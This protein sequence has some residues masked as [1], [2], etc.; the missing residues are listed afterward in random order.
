MGPPQPASLH[1]NGLQTV[2]LQAA[3]RRSSGTQLPE[4]VI[5]NI[6]KFGGGVPRCSVLK[7]KAYLLLHRD[8]RRN[9]RYMKSDR[10]YADL[11]ERRREDIFGSVSA[12]ANEQGVVCKEKCSDWNS[13]TER[14]ISKSVTSHFDV[15]TSF[16]L[17]TRT[18]YDSIKKLFPPVY[19]STPFDM[20]LRVLKEK[21]H[22]FDTPLI[23]CY[24]SGISYFVGEKAHF[25]FTA[26]AGSDRFEI[27]QFN[28]E[29]PGMFLSEDLLKVSIES[30][31]NY[32]FQLE[33]DVEDSVD[34]A[35]DAEAEEFYRDQV[36]FVEFSLGAL[37]G[38]KLL[39]SFKQVARRYSV[40]VPSHFL[41][42]TLY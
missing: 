27:K 7:G 37:S 31:K 38:D 42:N 24:S 1:K 32:T 11:Y 3:P 2:S 9:S 20:T 28:H 22:F 26:V 5:Q 40:N 33:F 4:E 23:R 10:F 34:A 36:G 16:Y 39:S 6:F 21:M 18:L 30:L 14:C 29:R 15:I 19:Q 17:V 13:Y 8:H 12:I 25:M 41:K 35:Y